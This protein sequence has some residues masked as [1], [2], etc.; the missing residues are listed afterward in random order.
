MRF[1]NL[2][3]ATGALI[4][5]AVMITG[6]GCNNAAP[7]TD[8]PP[9]VPPQSTMII[10]FSDFTSGGNGGEST[11]RVQ[12][13]LPGA[14]FTF[15]AINLAIWNTVVTVTLAVPVVA[16]VES[17]DHEPEQLDSGVW[18][19]SYSFR[20][21]GVEH[22]A[23]LQADVSNNGV[24]WTMLISKEGEYTD[25][26]W[27]TGQSNLAGT[28]GTWTLN[29]PPGDDPENPGPF[30]FIEWNRD[31]S[32]ETGDIKYT[33]ITPDSPEFGGFIFYGVT[34]AAP[35]NA[36]YTIASAGD[37]RTIEI[38]F[39][40]ETIAGRVRD[41]IHFNDTEW[42]CWDEALQNADCPE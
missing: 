42:H 25:F 40:T 23:A 12:Q 18:E 15:A 14:N 41:E 4:V 13:A 34:G 8:T 27:F 35:F 19:W 28:A 22:S 20:I 16:F 2:L 36:F 5:A 31:P 38:E 29:H 3:R 9:D 7:P 26:E 21:N 24:D 17:F 10:D 39:N 32:A 11:A 37:D 6:S 1:E 33:N 30:I